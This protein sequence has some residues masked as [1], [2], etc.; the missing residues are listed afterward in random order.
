MQNYVVIVLMRISQINPSDKH[1]TNIIFVFLG[2]ILMVSIKEC[3]ISN[4]PFQYSGPLFVILSVSRYLDF[5]DT[6]EVSLI[7]P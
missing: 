5:G 7:F 6:R 3:I 2:E 4:T 1:F